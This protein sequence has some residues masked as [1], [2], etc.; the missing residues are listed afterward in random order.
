M[1]EDAQIRKDWADAC[2]VHRQRVREFDQLVAEAR[3]IMV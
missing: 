3:K 1:D 2:S